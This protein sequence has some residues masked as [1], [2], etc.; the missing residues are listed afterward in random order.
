MSKYE[1]TERTRVRRLPDRGSYDRATVH[2]ILDEALIAHVGITT[3]NGP[4]VLPLTFARIDETVYFHGAVANHL[5]RTAKGGT[6]VC[7]TV[8]LLDGLVLAKSAFHHSM[9]YRCVVAMGEA[10]VVEEAEEKRLALD[11]IVDRVAPARSKEAR[12]PNDSELRSTLVLALPLVEVS[13]KIRTGGPID[14]E[15]DADWPA[16]AGVI[17]VRMTLE[18][19]I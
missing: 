4:V 3:P 16:R 15:A 1:P 8:T 14:D 2:A 13:A 5:L 17:P 7:L 19:R 10:R 9:N 18:R 11:A 6:E 12:S